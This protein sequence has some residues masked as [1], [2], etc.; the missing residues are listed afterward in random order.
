MATDE[1]AAQSKHSALVASDRVEGTAVYGPGNRRIG[2]I[3]RLM[4]DKASGKIAYAVL[5]FGG[6]LGIGED[7]YPL[8]WTKLRYDTA[9]D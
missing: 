3:E 7:H 9:L 1:T 6:F 2:R 8:P 4:I 5:T